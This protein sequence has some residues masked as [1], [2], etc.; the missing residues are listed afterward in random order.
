[1]AESDVTTTAEEL[2]AMQSALNHAANEHDPTT[3]LL[4]LEAYYRAQTPVRGYAELANLTRLLAEQ[5]YH[6]RAKPILLAG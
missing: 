3:I 4:D 1:M 2:A 6:Q 5:D